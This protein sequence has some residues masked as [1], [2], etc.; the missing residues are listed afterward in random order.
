M[1]GTEK[2]ISFIK[3]NPNELYELN[4]K[5]MARLL[6]FLARMEYMVFGN[7]RT[8]IASILWILTERFGVRTDEGY[9][10]EVPLTHG[11]IANL[12]GLARETTSLEMEHLKKKGVINYHGK[13]ILVKSLV[14]L[15]R[16]S[17][18]S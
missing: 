16:E 5:M 7:A 12:V 14:R 15:K 6:G 13:K 10:I 1:V 4:V 2:F 3:G 9:L 17:T 11:D 18:K 8:K